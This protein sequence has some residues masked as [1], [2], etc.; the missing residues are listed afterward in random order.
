LDNVIEATSN[1]NF[2]GTDCSLP[3]LAATHN[4]LDLDAFIVLTDSETWAGRVHPHQALNAY[5]SKF[6]SDAK[7]IVVGMT[8]NKFTIADPND[9]GS[10]DVVGYDTAT[11]NVISDFIRG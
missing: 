8:A 11:P 4:N 3:M 1:I 6:V 9:A 10:L 5:R 7:L 2:G